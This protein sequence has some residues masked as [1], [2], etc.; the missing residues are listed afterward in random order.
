M[1]F[2][3]I[4]ILLLIIIIIILEMKIENWDS[5]GAIIQLIAKDQQ[6]DY[7]TVPSHRYYPYPWGNYY[8]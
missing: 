1:D 4:I 3:Y 6:D 8:Y 2:S 5:G 7:L